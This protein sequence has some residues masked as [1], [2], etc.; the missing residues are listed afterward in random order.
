[1]AINETYGEVR[2]FVVGSGCK[3]NE[4]LSSFMIS[5]LQEI[6]TKV[7]DCPYYAQT[8]MLTLL[9][10]VTRLDVADFAT[11]SSIKVRYE[12]DGESKCRTLGPES[13]VPTAQCSCSKGD[14]DVCEHDITGLPSSFRL[15][16]D[17]LYFLPIPD[18]QVT[19]EISGYREVSC[20]LYTEEDDVRTWNAVD[21]P[22][23]YQSVFRNLVLSKSFAESKDFAA[24]TY[25]EQKASTGL[26]SL[27]K[28]KE[29]RFDSTAGSSTVCQPAPFA[30]ILRGSK[31]ACGSCGNS[32]C[33]CNP[34]IEQT[35]IEK[36]YV[37]CDGNVIGKDEDPQFATGKGGRLERIN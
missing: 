16:N 3:G 28:K 29:D 8:K 33:C 23:E 5:C 13:T 31:R 24:A 1:M 32:T 37:D 11:I 36:V 15:E 14:E 7:C 4:R 34:N 26:D 9:P 17:Y 35:L 25:W 19:I 6:W 20:E 2:D 18:E 21:L 30:A 12:K 22:P 27:I 10:G